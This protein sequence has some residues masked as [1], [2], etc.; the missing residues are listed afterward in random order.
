MHMKS[1]IDDSSKS[2]REDE[3]GIDKFYELF[4]SRQYKGKVFSFLLTFDSCDWPF[5]L[6]TTKLFKVDVVQIS[7]DPNFILCFIL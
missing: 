7:L 4:Y 2:D 5:Y 6:F 3:P 1:A